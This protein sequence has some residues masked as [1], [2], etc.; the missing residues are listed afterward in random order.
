VSGWGG[1]FAHVTPLEIVEETPD[2]ERHVA[3][4]DRTATAL[5]GIALGA[6]AVVLFFGLIRLLARRFAGSSSH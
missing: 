3:I 5:Q 4:T 1:A 2:G 6:V